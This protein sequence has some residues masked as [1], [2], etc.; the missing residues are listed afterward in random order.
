MTLEHLFNL[1][2]VLTLFA[3]AGFFVQWVAYRRRIADAADGN[4]G[5]G[6]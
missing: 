4:Q 5:G 2:A 6:R 3:V 1:L